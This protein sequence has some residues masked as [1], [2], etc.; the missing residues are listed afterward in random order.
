M[1]DVVA[2]KNRPTE[3]G[4]VGE[5]EHRR[6]KFPI[7]EF[8]S[9]YPG[10]SYTLCNRTP[11]TNVAYPVADITTDAEW[12]YWIVKSSDL[13]RAGTGEC[14]LIVSV[15]GV[16]AKSVIYLTHVDRALGD[17]GTAPAPWDAWQEA[18][19]DLKDDAEQAAQDAEEAASH[20]PTIINGYWYVWDVSAGEYVNTGVPASGSG[21]TNDYDQLIHR[22]QI[23]GNTLTGNKTAADL[24]LVAAQQGY[25]LIS[26]ADA[27]QIGTNAQSIVTIN[28]KIPAAASPSNQ[29][30]DKA[31][32]AD[33]ITQGTA[34]FRGSY[35]SRAALLA[36][37]WQTT[38]PTANYYVS[39][40][41]YA[42]VLDDETQNDECWRY[43]Y[44]A[45]TGWTA[46]YRINESP[47]TN[48]QL[49]ALNSGVTAETVAKILSSASIDNAGLI[50]YKNAN[51][52]AVFTLQLPLYD[53]G[54]T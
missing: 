5:N 26:N 2:L 44:V 35:A 34:I 46:Q 32:V 42:V 43:I 41:D 9:M 40:N 14:E 1:I 27:A 36:V 49:A 12:L 17:S 37:A 30:A 53:G 7:A 11:G 24:G 54:V 20:Y 47:L 18:F 15:D 31:Y 52:T 50:T 23:N 6:V 10:A 3:L 25:G 4:R 16:V 29:L 39:N 22:P 51:N 19:T 33:S 45:G 13:T 38:D 28:G 48:A 8:A 21:G